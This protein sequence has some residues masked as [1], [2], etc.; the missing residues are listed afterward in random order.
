ML[1]FNNKELNPNF[2]QTNDRLI[3]ITSPN[4]SLEDLYIKVLN[5][6]DIRPLVTITAVKGFHNG[7]SSYKLIPL[8]TTYLKDYFDIGSVKYFADD[9]EY[10]ENGWGWEPGERERAIQNE[11]E[12]I[13]VADI[14]R[15]P[16]I[17]D[18]FEK[19]TFHQP[20]GAAYDSLEPWTDYTDED[21][22]ME[23]GDALGI[24]P[25]LQSHD[26]PLEEQKRLSNLGKELFLP[27]ALMPYS[28]FNGL[29][30]VDEIKA[31]AELA[32]VARRKI[33][34]YHNFNSMQ[35]HPAYTLAL[36][37]KTYNKMP[38]YHFDNRYFTDE[39]YY[40]NENVTTMN[41]IPEY[42][43]PVLRD[44]LQGV[45]DEAT[46][47]FVEAYRRAPQ[48][49]PEMVKA[50]DLAE[51]VRNKEQ[52][53]NTLLNGFNLQSLQMVSK[54]KNATL[55]YLANFIN[56]REIKENH[57]PIFAVSTAPTLISYGINRGFLPWYQ[58]YKSEISDSDL[59]IIVKNIAD[60][61]AFDVTKKPKDYIQYLN[62]RVGYE[63]KESYE[64]K[65]NFSFEDNIL[66][67][68]GSDVKI[69]MDGYTMYMLPPEDIRNFTVG[70]D[71][72]C[73]QH[74][75]GAGESCTY[76][77]VTDPYAGICVIEKNG[78]IKAQG[79]I[80]TDEA[81][82][83]LV[84]DNVEFANADGMAERDRVREILPMFGLFAESIPYANVHIGTGYNENMRGVGQRIN[85]NE[86]AMLPENISNDYTYSDY[87]PDGTNSARTIKRAGHVLID[88]NNRCFVEHDQS[89]V[90]DY[91]NH[92][93]Y[94]ILKPENSW[95]NTLG[96]S[97]SQKMELIREKETINQKTPEEQL[98]FVKR[99]IP[100]S[101][102][103]EYPSD[104]IQR[105]I[106]N[107]DKTWLSK[108]QH[109][110]ENLINDILLED[111]PSEIYNPERHFT[112][113][114]QIRVYISHPDYL[115]HATEFD[116][117]MLLGVAE[118]NAYAILSVP[119]EYITQDIKLKAIEQNPRIISTFGDRELIGRKTL[120]H[121]DRTLLTTAIRKDREILRIIG[122][123]AVLPED[124]MAQAVREDA[125][126]INS[127]NNPSEAVVDIAITQNPLLIRNFQYKYPD[128]ALK[129]VSINPRVINILTQPTKEMFEQVPDIN[130]ISV[131]RFRSIYADMRAAGPDIQTNIPEPEL[132]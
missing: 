111:C 10:D 110:N 60:I 95:I 61:T 58:R 115:R 44:V 93:F 14:I 64:E 56:F 17:A 116:H 49:L 92:P 15:R 59:E 66:A 87:H 90:R 51:P 77:A 13:I 33:Y 65:Y 32:P 62:N 130:F 105:Y 131:P 67:I 86:F 80:W 43:R 99:C 47:K 108:L 125:S 82:D 36:T 121:Y 53:V 19:Q 21:L 114:Q 81:K 2:F 74:Y 109:V 75:R 132:A 69:T 38:P 118:Q 88:T 4:L 106:I 72:S 96:L 113:E 11:A 26:V 78:K 20:I 12:R 112:V 107:T 37:L 128:L 6:E 16:Q 129:A 117:N 28:D 23:L 63:D 52:A 98:N 54:Y 34:N 5:G 45:F 22:I 124:I 70:Y 79:F 9:S 48:V 84:F 120:Y 46:T 31:Y 50:L 73:C 71:T 103:I 57:I 83:T 30:S 27:R 8:R 126:L 119:K 100:I 102:F 25:A 3:K 35:G 122:P 24:M 41:D 39:A 68:R 85:N 42:T 104:D 76:K 7:T 123:T 29:P 94:E 1:I 18:A 91:S 97:L 101:Q 40:D 55:L 89:L 127:F